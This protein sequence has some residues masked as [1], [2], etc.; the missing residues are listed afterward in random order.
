MTHEHTPNQESLAVSSHRSLLLR[1]SSL[2]ARALKDLRT[3]QSRTLHFPTD[4]SFGFL[5]VRST[6]DDWSVGWEELGDAQGTVV[7]PPHTQL[8]LTVRRKYHH[9]CDLS[10]LVAFAPDDLQL[11]NLGFSDVTDD[12]LANVRRLTG[13]RCVTVWGT[14]ITDAGL[15]HLKDLKALE[16]LILNDTRVTDAGLNHLLSLTRLE[17]LGLENTRV[18]EAGLADLRHHL[19]NLIEIE[20]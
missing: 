5:R 3:L 15:V 17:R 6:G 11:L 19:P 13:L 10:V 12:M 4:R 2:V 18:T 16:C 9:P 20:Y 8:G 7:V 1:S 14:P